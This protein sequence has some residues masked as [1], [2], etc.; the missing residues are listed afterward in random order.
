[1]VTD[2]LMEWEDVVPKSNFAE[3]V[4]ELGTRARK[5]GDEEDVEKQE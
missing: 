3:C 4:E 2:T 5:V 1:M